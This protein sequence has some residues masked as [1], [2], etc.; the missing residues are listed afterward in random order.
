MLEFNDPVKN[1][2]TSD[3]SVTSE[4]AYRVQFSAS[5]PLTHILSPVFL[6]FLNQRFQ[7]GESLHNIIGC[8]FTFYS[9][10]MNIINSS[11]IHF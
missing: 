8:R 9:L 3:R 7:E 11:I 1:G 10:F 5:V 2:V 6:L 4:Q